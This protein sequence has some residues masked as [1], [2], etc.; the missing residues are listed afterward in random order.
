MEKLD[1]SIRAPVTYEDFAEAIKAITTGGAPGP[2]DHSAN[3]VKAWSESTTKIVFEH[4]TNIWESRFSPSWFKDKVVKLAP[5]IPGNTDL[6]NMRPISLY[7]VIRK[8]W[9]TI[10]S[11]R[12]NLF[13]HNEDILHP[14]QHGYRLDHGTYMALFNVIN[15]VEHAQHTDTTKQATFWDIRRAFDSIPRNIQRLAWTRLGLPQDVAEWFVSL[16][17]GGLSFIA[18]PLYLTTRDL[19]TPADMLQDDA[20]MCGNT[21][22]GF[23]AERGIGQGESA[24]SLLWIAMYDILLEWIDPS[25]RHLHVAEQIQDT[26]SN[27]DAKLTKTN[28]YADDLCTTAAGPK[29]EYMHQLQATWL[30]A[31]CAFT[32]LEMHPGKIH[33]TTIGPPPPTTPLLHIYDARWKQLPCIV[34]PKMKTVRY[35]GID[36]DLRNSDKTAHNRVLTDLHCRLSHLL[37]QPGSPQVKIEYIRNK[38]LPIAL[39]T[40]LCANWALS[41]Y[42]ALDAPLSIAYRKIL[43]L[44]KHFPTALLY[45]PRKYCGIGLPRLSDRSQ[46]MKWES[47]QRSLAIGGESK[48]A[49]NDIIE[50]VPH[51]TL[52]TNQSINILQTTNWP[53]KR[54]YTARSFVEWAKESNMSLAN[55]RFLTKKEHQQHLKNDSELARCAKQVQLW[56]DKEQWGDSQTLP[57]M[58]AFFTDGSYKPQAATTSDILTPD[59]QLRDNGEGGG[60][61]VFVP[62]FYLYNTITNE[63]I[64]IRIT[65]DQPEPGMN[66]FHWELSTQLVALQLAKYLPAYVTGFTDCKGAMA[67][68]NRALSTR[69]DQ[70]ARTCGGIFS[71]AI[72]QMSHPDCPR[73]YQWVRGHPDRDPARKDLHSR[74]D[75]GIFMAD[76]VAE[77]DVAALHKRGFDSPITTLNFSSVINEIIPLNLW[78][79]RTDSDRP[80][81]ILDDIINHQHRV[82]LSSYLATRDK[83]KPEP[84]WTITNLEFTHRVHPLP[85]KSFWAAARRTATIFDWLGHGRN[86]AKTK[87]D[88]IERAAAALCLHCGGTDSQRHSILE[89]PHTPFIEIRER[90]QMKQAQIAQSLLAQTTNNNM[91]YYIQHLCYSSWIPSDNTDRLWLGTWTLNMLD[92]YTRQAL[93]RPLSAANRYTYLAMTKKLLA[94]LQEAYRAILDINIK[95][96]DNNVL[97]NDYT[98]HPDDDDDDTDLHQADPREEDTVHTG[99]TLNIH[100]P[101]NPILSHS[102]HLELEALHPQMIPS[103]TTPLLQS[104]ARVATFNTFTL[105]DSAHRLS[106][107]GDD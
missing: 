27:K 28:A 52:P 3:M 73:R 87:T 36:L 88:P 48:Q 13:W 80:V 51:T 90:A 54:S 34:D 104:I 49:V 45:L 92:E 83:N 76:A 14:A 25:K 47:F 79:L 77:G 84:K 39:Y 103:R 63:P 82:L 8:V 29:A 16:D 93:N 38:I 12:I 94:P 100:D 44:P 95:R 2:S 57:H 75:R 42:R 62:T 101:D 19:K 7:E 18:S 97:K 1:N 71:S 46:M 61:I 58:S 17:D 86:Q 30:S 106:V 32:G 74:Q 91:T 6:K 64:F 78:H 26:Y 33:A 11:K 5:K 98:P 37:L 102:D 96:K 4:M 85:N 9:T 55:R 68:T 22:L 31:F 72:N 10:L 50:R 43:S 35:L 59:Q 21:G 67:R 41:K 81:P 20:H 15:E 69:N 53:T 56:P 65:S 23:V 99:S 66:A 60:G 107:P 89:C 40:T 70:L 24:S 105:S